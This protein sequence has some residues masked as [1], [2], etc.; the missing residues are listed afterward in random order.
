MYSKFY[1]YKKDIFNGLD[2]MCIWIDVLNIENLFDY[3]FD[4]KF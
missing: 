1:V 4:G 2:I 3:M